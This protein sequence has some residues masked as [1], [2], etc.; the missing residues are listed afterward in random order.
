MIALRR[1]PAAERDVLAVPDKAAES[2]PPLW[3]WKQRSSLVHVICGPGHAE[4]TAPCGCS[5]SGIPPL[6]LFH[7]QHLASKGRETAGLTWRVH[8]GQAWGSRQ[9][10][11][12]RPPLLSPVAGEL[13]SERLHVWKVFRRKKSLHFPTSKVQRCGG[14][15]DCR[16]VPAD[17]QRK[18]S[19][20]SLGAV[21]SVLKKKK[22]IKTQTIMLRTAAHVGK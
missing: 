8:A 10:D 12:P 1:E 14:G 11:P 20:S 17:R 18:R 19:S 3:G 4:G 16:V 2:P 22:I 7:L 6:W 15:C 9:P 13:G 21:S 5:G